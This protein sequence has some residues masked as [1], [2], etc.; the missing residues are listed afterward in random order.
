[1]VQGYCNIGYKKSNID[2]KE[3]TGHINIFSTLYSA[4]SCLSFSKTVLHEFSG[5]NLQEHARISR[6]AISRTKLLGETNALHK[7]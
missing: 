3:N 5:K 7:G 4:S 2:I 1:M 6:D